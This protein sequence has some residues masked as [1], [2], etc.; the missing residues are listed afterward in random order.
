VT[1]RLFFFIFFFIGFLLSSMGCVRHQIDETNFGINPTRRGYVPARIALTSCVVWPDRAT[2]IKGVPMIN[3]PKDEIISICEDFDKYVAD[4]FDNQ[5]YMK[6]LSPKLVEKLY[7][8]AGLNPSIPD[9]IIQEWRSLANDC[10]DCDNLPTFYNQSIRSRASWQIWLT[11]FS[12]A[13][14]GSDAIMI[15]FLLSANTRIEDDRGVWQSIRGGALAILLIDTND[16]SLVWSGGRETDVIYKALVN[17]T[18][19]SEL[20]EPPLEDL[21]RRLLTDALWLEFPGRQIYR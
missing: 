14:K 10:Q 12:N 2:R 16:G 18:S 15:P 3:R 1:G 9:T 5:P 21:K 7:T 4:G 8:A 20:K 13:T 6:G 11:K 17:T 19:K